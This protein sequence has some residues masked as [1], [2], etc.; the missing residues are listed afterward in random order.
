MLQMDDAFYRR[1]SLQNVTVKKISTTN[2][3]VGIFFGK[4]FI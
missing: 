2:G 1:D 3:F 4:T